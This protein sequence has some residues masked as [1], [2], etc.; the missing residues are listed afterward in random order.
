MVSEH[1]SREECALA[2]PKFI[3]KTL[4]RVQVSC[5]LRQHV[6]VGGVYATRHAVAMER[7]LAR[8]LI[9]TPARPPAFYAAARERVV[10]RTHP[11]ENRTELFVLF[12]RKK[13]AL[14]IDHEILAHN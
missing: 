4:Q 9:E 2:C 6:V 11:A 13:T 5:F 7:K 1:Y 10:R 8:Q 3:D 14:E 12:L